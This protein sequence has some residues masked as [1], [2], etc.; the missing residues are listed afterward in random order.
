MGGGMQGNLTASPTLATRA[1]AFV[2]MVLLPVASVFQVP[3]GSLA[4]AV[5]PGLGLGCNARGLVCLGV[6]RF[7]TGDGREE[8][9]RWFAEV[10]RLLAT[11][12]GK[13]STSQLSTALVARHSPQLIE[14]ESSGSRDDIFG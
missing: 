12:S 9:C 14:Y 11:S 4:P 13:F 10:C 2:E 6:S 7:R 8:R 3:P 5:G 1:V